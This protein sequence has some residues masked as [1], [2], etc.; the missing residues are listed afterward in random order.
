MAGPKDTRQLARYVVVGVLAVFGLVTAFSE[1]RPLD[2]WWVMMIFGVL[3]I[4]YATSRKKDDDDNGQSWFKRI[5]KPQQESVEQTRDE[6]ESGDR[7]PHR[8]VRRS[9]RLLA[10]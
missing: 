2:S 10:I 7:G 1:K 9:R 6:R 8:R 4:D 3:G 5:S